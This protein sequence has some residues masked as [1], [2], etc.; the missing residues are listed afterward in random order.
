MLTLVVQTTRRTLLEECADG[1][2]RVPNVNANSDGDF[3]F[4]LGNFE[5]VWNQNNAFLA[6]DSS[7]IPDKATTE[8]NK[9]K[10]ALSL[11][12]ET[13]EETGVFEEIK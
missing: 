7:E 1:Y 8:I 4:N 13:N 3:N 10:K 5:N 9:I 11:K 12:G 2:H 6:T